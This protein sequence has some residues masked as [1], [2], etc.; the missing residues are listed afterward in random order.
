MEIAK[1][2]GAGIW[3]VQNANVLILEQHTMVRLPVSTGMARDDVFL[4]AC[5]SMEE[6]RYSRSGSFS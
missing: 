1:Y 5:Y 6:N 3:D 4:H 2:P